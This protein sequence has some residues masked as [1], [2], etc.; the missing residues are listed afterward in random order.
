MLLRSRYQ[1]GWCSIIALVALRL[2]IGAH[3]YS[4]GAKKLQN[5]KPFSGPFLSNA[6]GPMA[7]FY[8]GMI[9]DRDGRIRLDQKRTIERWDEYKKQIASHYGFTDEQTK[10]IENVTE[11]HV[12]HL[13]DF[14]DENAEDVDKY[15]KGLDRRDEN[16]KNKARQNVKSLKG[17][18]VRIERER[19]SLGRGLLSSVDT[20]WAAY[21]RDANAV[22]TDD[23]KNRGILALP[24]PSAPTISSETMDRWVPYFDITIGALLFLGLF[25]RVAGSAAAIF[26]L[27]II[28]SQWPGSTG[29]VATWPQSI[30]M[31]G[32]WVLIGTGAGRFCGID[33]IIENLIKR[34]CSNRSGASNE[35]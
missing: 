8:Q 28:A 3:F 23:Q 26:L 24:K 21:E 27:S 31:I 16:L 19:K 5:P 9:W 15:L 20:L 25:T 33:V 13:Q 6:K 32:L 35:S 30:E 1:L 17:Q 4:E 2:L 7:D 11:D 12:V 34:C 22:A 10:K 18:V 14:F 29:A